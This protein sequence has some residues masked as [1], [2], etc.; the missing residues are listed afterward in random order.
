MYVITWP[1]IIFKVKGFNNWGE[2]VTRGYAQ[3]YLPSSS[4]QYMKKPYIYTI[5]KNEKWYHRWLPFLEPDVGTFDDKE[6][7]R[8]IVNG[9]GR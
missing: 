7:E 1:Q 3:L 2:L 5:I 4:G 6:F 8:V 9:E